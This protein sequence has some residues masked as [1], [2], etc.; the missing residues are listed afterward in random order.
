M[1]RKKTEEQIE[2]AKTVE[3]KK[4]ASG[5]MRPVSYM[6]RT[7]PN[8]KRIDAG[9]AA[10]LKVIK[11]DEELYNYIVSHKGEMSIIQYANQLI[12]KAIEL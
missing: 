6:Q 3:H 5:A 7:K 8:K 12:R 10:N 4:N 11:I 1:P 2:F 9:T